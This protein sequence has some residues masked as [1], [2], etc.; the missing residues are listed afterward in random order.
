M[1]DF[2]CGPAAKSP[3][4]NAVDSEVR[5]LVWEDS[6]CLK[7]TKPVSHNYALVPA[8]HNYRA[9]ILKG[10][11]PRAHAVQQEKPPQWEACTL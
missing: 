1:L 3:T 8:S 4:H 7:P 11:H 5:S 6:R 10:K 2:P 9:H